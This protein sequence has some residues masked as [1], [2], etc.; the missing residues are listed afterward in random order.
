[1]STLSQTTHY[2]IARVKNDF[3][4]FPVKSYKILLRYLMPIT[5]GSDPDQAL[6]EPQLPTWID[7]W[8]RLGLVNVSFQEYLSD[9]DYDWVQKRAE[10]LRLAAQPDISNIA[11][12]KGLLQ[13]SDFGLQFFRAVS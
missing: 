4:G 11:F 10:Y 6:E 9:G 1:M 2:P 13:A 3:G 7:N 12:D 5:E 8:Q